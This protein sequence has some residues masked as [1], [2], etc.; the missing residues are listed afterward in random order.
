MKFENKTS[1]IIILVFLKVVDKRPRLVIVKMAPIYFAYEGYWLQFFTVGSCKH[2]EHEGT[3]FEGTS[4]TV[5]QLLYSICGSAHGEVVNF[6]LIVIIC[7]IPKSFFLG[8]GRE[9]IEIYM[10]RADREMYK[11][12][13]C[14]Y[15]YNVIEAK[16]N[17]CF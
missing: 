10:L 14:I 13:P 12:F 15:I 9:N 2:S 11:C 1:I 3:N 7:C 8:G 17:F 4:K 16:H 6:E 5:F